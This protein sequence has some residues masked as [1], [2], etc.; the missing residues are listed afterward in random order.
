MYK[1]I[2]IYVYIYVYTSSENTSTGDRSWL[3][4]PTSRSAKL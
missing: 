4:A 2:Y 1:Y 3:V